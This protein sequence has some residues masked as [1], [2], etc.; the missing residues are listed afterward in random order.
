MGTTITF[1]AVA[2]LLLTLAPALAQEEHPPANL[3]FYCGSSTLY[4]YE[5]VYSDKENCLGSSYGGMSVGQLPRSAALPKD[6][7]YC[8][9]AHTGWYQWNPR[10]TPKHLQKYVM[11]TRICYLEDRGR[12]QNINDLKR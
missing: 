2:L 6:E 7:K 5:P 1:W 8:K 3:G 10:P 4:P 11:E 12:P 9:W